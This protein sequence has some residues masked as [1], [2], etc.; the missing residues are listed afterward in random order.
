VAD[1]CSASASF[2]ALA[3]MREQPERAERLWAAVADEDAGA[4]LGGWRR[5]RHNLEAKI[6]SELGGAW[7]S[8][9]QTKALTLDDA[10]TLAVGAGSR[11]PAGGGAGGADAA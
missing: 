1:V 2:A 3:G 9:D 4:P 8:P 10:V 5:H 6:G 11:P 7:R